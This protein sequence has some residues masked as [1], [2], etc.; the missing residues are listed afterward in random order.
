ML[1]AELIF[2]VQIIRDGVWRYVRQ[3]A[4]NVESDRPPPCS[5]Q[6]RKAP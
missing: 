6:W 3:T 2:A 5:H 1:V 4:S